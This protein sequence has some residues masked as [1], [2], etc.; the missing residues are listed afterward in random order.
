MLL[1]SEIV[2]CGSE[3]GR[4]TDNDQRY[5]DV[6]LT[7]DRLATVPEVPLWLIETLRL[8]NRFPER[9]LLERETPVT[10]PQFIYNH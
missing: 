2:L 10:P 3:D 6:E 5:R 4:M 8:V 1:R 9:Y 7:L